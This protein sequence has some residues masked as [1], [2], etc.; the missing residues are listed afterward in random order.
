MRE[1]TQLLF[2]FPREDITEEKEKEKKETDS[3][4]DDVVRPFVPAVRSSL[5][6]PGLDWTVFVLHFEEET[7]SLFLAGDVG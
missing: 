1:D 4:V 3:T 6:R 2:F 5:F 7:H